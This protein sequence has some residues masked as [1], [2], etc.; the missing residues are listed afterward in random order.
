MTDLAEE[1]A[2]AS[3]G[4]G[5]GTFRRAEVVVV[6]GRGE[7]GRGGDGGGD[8]ALAPSVLLLHGFGS[9]A[10]EVGSLFA[11]LAKDLAGRG[12]A[13]LRIDFPGCGASQRP[14][15]E[16]RFTGMVGEAQSALAWLRHRPELDASRVGVLGFSLGAKVAAVVAG[17][18][19]ESDNAVRALASWSGALENSFGSLQFLEDFEKDIA[20]AGTVDGYVEVDLGWQ[21]IELG[22]G[23]FSDMRD[24][25]P[26]ESL[27]KHQNPL[28]LV[29]GGKDT[30]VKPEVSRRAVAHTRS[31]DVVLREIPDA[32]HT[33][34]VLT[35]G[36]DG[37]ASAELL[38]LST[39][40]FSQQLM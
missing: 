7:G 2:V 25:S 36:D 19:A 33:W 13:S 22:S 28:L 11:R 34:N 21:K 6:V 23:W 18:A 31:C 1:A 38:A 16:N 40:W 5:P 9:S 27:P 4:F 35:E 39:N 3:D 32:D 26:L 29:V 15:R 20:R 37:R 24:S 8:P 17:E 14:H 30:L 12:I 10:D